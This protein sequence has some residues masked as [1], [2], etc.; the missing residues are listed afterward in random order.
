MLGQ[1][2]SHFVN[3]TRIVGALEGKVAR[4]CNIKKTK[5][6]TQN[7]CQRQ[8]ETDQTATYCGA[9]PVSTVRSLSYTE[10]YDTDPYIHAI[11][12][13]NFAPPVSRASKTAAL[14]SGTSF[15]S[16]LRSSKCA[17]GTVTSIMRE[18]C[19]PN[20][21]ACDS[22]TLPPAATTWEDKEMNGEG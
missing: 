18:K 2:R 8:I 19:E 7:Q 16:I 12:G 11:C 13:V 9:V 5:I 17:E 20:L 6:V 4:V 15:K 10:Q 14:I 1:G 3:N 22:P 21:A